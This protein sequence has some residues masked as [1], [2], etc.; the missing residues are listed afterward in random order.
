M[1]SG[2]VLVT[3]ANGLLG[4]NIVDEL[5]KRGYPAV[6]LVRKNSNRLALAGLHCEIFEGEVTRFSDL[7]KAISG[8]SYVIHCA[9]STKQLI[10]TA[11]HF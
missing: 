11:Q 2:K 7:E 9:A 3:G 5:I 10:F 6:A 4:S 1:A 8:C